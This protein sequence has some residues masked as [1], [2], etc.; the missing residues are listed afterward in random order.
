MAGR[1]G[2]QLTNSIPG[3]L[4]DRLLHGIADHS[5][6][7]MVAVLCLRQH[8][9]RSFGHRKRVRRTVPSPQIRKVFYLL[10]LIDRRLLAQLRRRE[11]EVE[12]CRRRQAVDGELQGTNTSVCCCEMSE[13]DTF[14][15]PIVAVLSSAFDDYQSFK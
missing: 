5:K 7:I 11:E 3:R 4:D 9:K 6:R 2:S 12:C 1:P 13:A 15:H 8:T 10:F 14:L